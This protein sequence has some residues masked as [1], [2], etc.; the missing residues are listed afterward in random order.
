MSTEIIIIFGT[1]FERTSIIHA[2]SGVFGGLFPLIHDLINR[3]K[4]P[5]NQKISLNVEFW[6]IKLM[7]IPFAA[8]IL[9]VLCISSGNITSWFAA[10]YLGAT[11]TSFA[12]KL[13]GITADEVTLPPGA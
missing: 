13:V 4:Q 8:F 3:Q 2:T 7:L 10:L 12:E 1:E 5:D 9:T 11:F 6:L